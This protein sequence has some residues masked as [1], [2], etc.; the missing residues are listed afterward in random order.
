ME[1]L[2][3]RCV[4]SIENVN[5]IKGLSLEESLTPLRERILAFSISVPH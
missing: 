3:K 1:D 5:D 2:V 4:L